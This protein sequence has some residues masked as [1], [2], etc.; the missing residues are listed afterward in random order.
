[1]CPICYEE[2]VDNSPATFRLDCNHAVCVLCARQHFA[3]HIL[4]GETNKIHCFQPLCRVKPSKD[5]LKIL[6]LFDE[7]ILQ[8]LER[9][10]N[11]RRLE[12]DVLIRFCTR[13]DC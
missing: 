1:M 8:K 9:F 3:R 4:R 10:E 6:F 11:K 12:S 7:T 5:Q 2:P 13:P